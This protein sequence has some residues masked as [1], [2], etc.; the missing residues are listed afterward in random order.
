MKKIK[1]SKLI[2]KIVVCITLIVSSCSIE[3]EG[4]NVADENATVIDNNVNL[5][6]SFNQ[7]QTDAQRIV[8]AINLG[9]NEFNN[10]KFEDF[11][12]EDLDQ[13][14]IDAYIKQFGLEG[15]VNSDS[16]EINETIKEV[17]KAFETGAEDYIN[18]SSYA[19]YTKRTLI[20]QSSGI[21]IEDLEKQ[22]ARSD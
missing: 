3:D 9:I 18:N 21:V 17:A 1:L 15:L 5:T 14:T 10:P 13:K 4:I 16:R 11:L 2:I 22:R 19:D 12:N 8:N 7:K 20:I 6:A